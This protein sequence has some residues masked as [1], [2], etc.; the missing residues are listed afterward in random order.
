M[1][2]GDGG[3]AWMRAGGVRALGMAAWLRHF[4]PVHA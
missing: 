1:S 4:F 2:D 3:G